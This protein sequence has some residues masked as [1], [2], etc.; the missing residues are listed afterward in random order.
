M[1]PSPGAHVFLT[2]GLSGIHRVDLKAWEVV[3]GISAKVLWRAWE[4]EFDFSAP[5]EQRRL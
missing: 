2:S 5:V 3:G 4:C 1:V